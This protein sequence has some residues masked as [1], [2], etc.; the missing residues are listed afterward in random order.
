[1]KFYFRK[2]PFPGLLL[3]FISPIP[4]Q[5]SNIEIKQFHF[6]REDSLK[7]FITH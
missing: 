3:L 4:G 5:K 1:M 2:I 7:P 6:Q